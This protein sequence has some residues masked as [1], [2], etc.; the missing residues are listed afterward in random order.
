MEISTIWILSLTLLLLLLCLWLLF[1]SQQVL[2]LLK[3]SLRDQPWFKAFPYLVLVVMLLVVGAYVVFIQGWESHALSWLNLIVRWTHVIIGIAWIGASFYFVFLENSLN[4]TEG[5]RDELAGDLWAI[6]GGGFYYL[7]KYKVAPKVLPKKLHWFKYEA[8]FTW[9]T[10]FLLLII[11]YY[12]QSSVNMLGD[13]PMS[14][15]WAIAVGIGS[16][17]V[18]WKF[19][20]G[21]CRTPLI[22]QPLWFFLIMFVF[23]VLMA[24]LLSHLLSAKAAYIHV[25]AMLGS[26]MAGNVFEVIIPS[27]KAM[28][29]SAEQ[30]QL[31]DPKLGQYAGLRSLHNNYF[32]LPVVF[33]MI[34]NHFPSTYGHTFN[35]L[36]LGGLFLVSIGIRHY[37]NLVEKGQYAFWI[38]PAATL[39]VLVLALVTAP[40]TAN[41]GD[42]GATVNYRAIEPIFQQRCNTCHSENPSDEIWRA[43]PNGVMFDT[44]QQIQAMKDQILMRAVVTETMPL[45]NSTNMTAEE[46]ELLRRWILQGAEVGP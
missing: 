21:L 38:L 34:S 35:W 26:M 10:G 40:E 31:P 2:G 46:R 9:I 16:L 20:D 1:Q 32:T 19:Y 12:S 6:H 39:G 27:Q 37:L 28:V 41:K 25:G 14:P 30:G 33:V 42:L 29:K 5:L 23:T 7:E 4:R 45:G 13:F 18:G 22:H 44:P 15:G 17:I 24:A 11:V 43:A 3:T 36:I 8:Y